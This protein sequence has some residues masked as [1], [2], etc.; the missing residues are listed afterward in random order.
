MSIVQRSH[1]A[2][3]KRHICDKCGTSVKQPYLLKKHVCATETKVY[4]T[5][6]NLDPNRNYEN[7]PA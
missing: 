5:N 6:Q 1:R 3:D 7:M 2:K 4:A